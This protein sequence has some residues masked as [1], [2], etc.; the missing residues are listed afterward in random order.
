MKYIRTK[1]NQIIA[2]D[3]KAKKEDLPMILNY[4]KQIIAQADTPEELCDEFVFVLNHSEIGK[5]NEYMM[6]KK[7]NLEYFK[8]LVKD[9]K[10]SALYGAIWTDKGLIYVTKLDEKGDCNLI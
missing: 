2:Y 1:A 8:L 7:S 6:I 3:E 9:I 4:P 10:N 5:E